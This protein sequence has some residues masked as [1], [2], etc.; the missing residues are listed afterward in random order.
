M[1][2]GGLPPDLVNR[3]VPRSRFGGGTRPA[4]LLGLAFTCYLALSVV[5]WWHAWSTHPT[6]VTTCGCDDPSLFT[7][8]LEWPAYALAHG[9]NPFYST[10]LFHPEGINLLSN[11]GVLAIGIPLAPVTWIFGPIATLNVASTLGPALTALSM[12]WLLLRWVRW[13]PA[14]F[15]GGL[16]F[17][18]SPFVVTNLAGAHLMSAVLVLLPL[19]VACLDDLL[20]RQRHRPLV[21]GGALGVLVALQF[22]VSTEVLAVVALTVVAGVALL[23]AY[24]V[25]GHRRELA[26]RLPH[27]LRGTAAA[28]ALAVVLLAYPTWFALAGP[29]H[30]SGLVWPTIK[31]GAGGATLQ[32]LWQLRFLSPPALRLFAGYAGAGLPQ[33]EYLGLGMLVV[34]AAGV[35]VWRRDR[36]L[37]FFGALGVIAAVLSLG[38][39]HYWTPWRLL[40]GM[41]VVQNILP[42]CVAAITALCAGAM[43]AV[44]IDRVHGGVSTGVGRGAAPGEGRHLI[45]RSGARSGVRS[46]ARSGAFTRTLAATAA[47]VAVAAVAVVPL[48]TAMAGNIPFTTQAVA[49]PRWFT[50]MGPGLPPGQVVLTFPPPVTGGSA[51]TWQAMDRFRFALATGAGPGSIPQRAGAERAGQTLITAA[52]S[53]FPTLAP[54]TASNVLAIRHALAGWGVTYLV[55]PDP[56]ALVPVQDRVAGTAW[57]IATFTLA[58][59]RPPRFSDDAWVWSGVRS[60]G[61]SRS[62]SAAAFAGCTSAQRLVHPSPSA[63]SECVMAASRPT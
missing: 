36:R 24:G 34:L 19:M 59:G 12:C 28:V 49:L 17:G 3:P 41:P 48:A 47:A 26:R 18:F 22:F 42:A 37:W 62:I 40:T 35:M 38:V 13:V 61:P 58:L 15:V 8:F 11:T 4:V 53:V 16:V 57:A 2:D 33:L 39:Q 31:P 27:A 56:Q 10:S 55:V 30:L 51:M 21:S 60:P 54:A 32:Y 52:A 29:A 14:A 50:T 1:R 7:W 9:H 44:V 25:I 20:V 6:T 46:G 63:V 43:L 5:L 23:V 45:A